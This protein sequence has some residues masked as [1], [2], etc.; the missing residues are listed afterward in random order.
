MPWTPKYLPQRIQFRQSMSN[1]AEHL[2]IDG[3]AVDEEWRTK[4]GELLRG[5]FREIKMGFTPRGGI[6]PHKIFGAPMKETLAEAIVG[7][8]KGRN[9]NAEYHF[10]V[11]SY[12]RGLYGFVKMWKLHESGQQSTREAIQKEYNELVDGLAGLCMGNT[13]MLMW[14][15][16]HIYGLAEAG[17]PDEGRWRD[18]EGYNP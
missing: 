14:G 9:D 6:I 5:G 16:Q 11:N 3:A 18:I 8:E 13:E 4:M 17:P 1:I 10:E 7:T 15:N 2:S 12:S